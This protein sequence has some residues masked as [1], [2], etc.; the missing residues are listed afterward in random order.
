MW[1]LYNATRNTPSKFEYEDMH[2]SQIDAVFYWYTSHETNKPCVLIKSYGLKEEEEKQGRKKVVTF[3][4]SNPITN[5]RNS[6]FPVVAMFYN[7]T[8]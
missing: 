8:S 6:D 2:R 5:P 3:D 4:H 7:F 1:I